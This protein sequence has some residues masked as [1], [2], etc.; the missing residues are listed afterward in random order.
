MNN[1]LKQLRTTMGLKQREL[2][3][4]LGVKT[5]LIGNWE[6][7]VAPIPK[8]R[9]YQIC[10]TFHVREE[11]FEKGEGSIFETGG[12]KWVGDVFQEK[13]IRDVFVRLTEKQ[14]KMILGALREFYDEFDSSASMS[15]DI[16]PQKNAVE[17][18][19]TKSGTDKK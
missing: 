9:I 12:N 13:F 6:S 3:D 14:Q 17:Q 8:T 5:G 1:R 18:V 7:G 15:L 10:T 16:S 2:A 19:A 11:W 4:K